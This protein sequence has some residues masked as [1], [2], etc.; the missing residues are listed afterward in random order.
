[1]KVVLFLIA[2]HERFNIS[3]LFLYYNVNELHVVDCSEWFIIFTVV[4]YGLTKSSSSEHL[5]LKRY[6]KTIYCSL[7]LFLIDRTDGYIFVLTV[8]HSM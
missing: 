4:L 8:Q 2:M 6:T 1:M 7:L 5:Q 3:P